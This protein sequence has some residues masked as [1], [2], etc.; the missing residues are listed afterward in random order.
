MGIHFLFSYWILGIRF[1]R[2]IRKNPQYG[3]ELKWSFFDDGFH[4]LA[5]GSEMRADWSGFYETYVAPDGF[6]LYPQKGIYY[7]MPKSGFKSP[8]EAS[9]VE[10]ILK[11]KTNAKNIG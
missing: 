1:R 5:N 8:E 9:F 2:D 4:L 3:K 7:W 10:A 11:Q 6:L